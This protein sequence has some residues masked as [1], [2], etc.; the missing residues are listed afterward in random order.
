MKRLPAVLLAIAA[1]AV[2]AAFASIV[3]HGFEDLAAAEAEKQRLETRARELAESIAETE[4]MV[5]A[6]RN[7]P[8]AVESVARVELG[9]VR[10]GET[11]LLL[12]TP[13]PPPAPSLTGPTPTPILS[14]RY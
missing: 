10:P 14:L 7:D 5:A 13:T 11:V 1:L 4:E 12:A 8:A 6:L 9:M 3:A 2:L